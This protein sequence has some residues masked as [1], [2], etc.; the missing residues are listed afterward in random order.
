MKQQEV[1]DT[2]IKK[3][4]ECVKYFKER[5]VYEQLFQ[6]MRKKYIS[7][8]H[9]GG[10]V[11]LLELNQEDWKQLGGFFRKDFEGKKEV[12]I[13]AV[14]MEKALAGSKF[15]ELRWEDILQNYF[16]EKLIDKK[17]QKQKELQEK[18]AF[19]QEIFEMI[20]FDIGH[21]WL[22]SVLEMQTEG[23]SLLMKYYREKEKQLKMELC[24]FLKAIPHLPFLAVEKTRMSYRLLPVFAAETTGNPHFFDVGTLGEQLLI[25]FLKSYIPGYKEKKLINVQEKANLFYEAGL[26]KDDLSNH[27]LAYGICGIDS[28]GTIHEGIE[29]FGKRKEPILL[30]LRTLTGLKQIRTQGAK[31]VYIV[32]NPAVFSELIKSWPK[33]TIL[34]GNGQIRLATFVLLDLFETETEFFYAGDFDPEGLLIAQKLKERYGEKVHFWKYQVKFY[35]KYQSEVKISAKSLKKLEKIYMEEL[36][37]IKKAMLK[38]KKAT[39]QEN[40][41]IEYLVHNECC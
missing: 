27:T 14:A 10:T 39:Y 23:Y 28:S 11:R 13:S 21:T 30:T 41:L 2:D 37:E 9:F 19:F 36:Q 12:S 15:S 6:K 25:Y 33:E 40:M 7:L 34:C 20:P 35:E 31:C 5:K 38:Q 26:L 8:G 32:E 29:D 16:Q 18:E 24:L 17:Q 22:E 3:L 1:K 4:E